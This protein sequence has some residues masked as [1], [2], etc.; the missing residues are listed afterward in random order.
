MPLTELVVG[1]RVRIQNQTTVW[2]IRW[3]RFGVITDILRDQQYTVLVDGSCCLTVR[4][5]HHLRKIE[6]P[7]PNLELEEEDE[8]ELTE[9]VPAIPSMFPNEPTTNAPVPEPVPEPKPES[10]PVP[11]MRSSRM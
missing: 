7:K 5:R 2:K 9:P 3:D 8:D 4:N 6:D 10:E 1:D 11:L